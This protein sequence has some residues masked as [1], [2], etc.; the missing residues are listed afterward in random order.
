MSAETVSERLAEIEA[1]LRDAVERDGELYLVTDAPKD[2]A[3]LVEEYRRLR[4]VLD[5]ETTRVNELER[6][7]CSVCGM[8]VAHLNQAGHVIGWG[9]A[10]GEQCKPETDWADVRAAVRAAGFRFHRVGRIESSRRFHTKSRW[11]LEPLAVNDEALQQP[12]GEFDLV[13]WW[14]EHE[15]EEDSGLSV[16]VRLHDRC[17]AEVSIES[18]SP[19][20]AF[21]AAATVGLLRPA[22]GMPRPPAE[23][24]CTCHMTDPSTWTTH[25][26]AVEPG[27]IYEPDPD[28]PE[29]GEGIA[30][31]GPGAVTGATNTAGGYTDRGTGV[32]GPHGRTEADEWLDPYGDET[33]PAHTLLIGVAAPEA[34]SCM[35]G[36]TPRGD[37]THAITNHLMEVGAENAEPDVDGWSLHSRPGGMLLSHDT[38]AD[39]PTLWSDGP[40][41]LGAVLAF[42]ADQ[43]D[44]DGD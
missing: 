26:S 19:V 44:T 37:G 23:G 20:Q 38:D 43:E 16:E 42:I 14:W 41:Q 35:C 1:H 28:C 30:I 40:M 18:A 6:L 31:P 2:L 32:G 13:Q 3:W 8:R 9:C 11:E 4:E 12:V 21:A 24:A 7:K 36:Y 15:G 17:G 27:S 33:E 34:V 39:M 5:A 25:G 22:S 29:H 10:D